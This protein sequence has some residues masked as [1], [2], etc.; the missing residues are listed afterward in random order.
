MSR[1]EKF[2]KFADVPTPKAAKGV[3]ALTGPDGSQY[4]GDSPLDC[5]RL[6]MADRVPPEVALGRIARSMND[7]TPPTADPA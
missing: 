3:W 6:E 5:I 1:L 2:L 7:A 4:F